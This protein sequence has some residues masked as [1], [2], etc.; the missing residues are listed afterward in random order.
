MNNKIVLLSLLV[1]S[2]CISYGQNTIPADI[3]TLSELTF[4]TNPIIKRNI[5]TVSNAEGG[6]K[7]QTSAF[8]YQL[9]SGLSLTRNN[10]NPFEADPRSSFLTGDLNSRFTGASVGLQRKFR[11]SFTVNLSVDYTM[12][13]DN[14][15]L[16]RFNQDVGAFTQEHIVTSTLSL[17]QPLLRGRGKKI[18][19]AL[20]EASKLNLESVDDN[21]EFANSFELL[22]LGTAYWQYVA[23]YKSLEVFE[24]N[25]ARV[26]RVLEITQE[27]VKADKKPAG[28][29]AQIQADLASQ[30]RQTKVAEQALYSAKLNLGRVI[31][32]SEEESKRLGNP[33]DEFPSIIE[34]GY[35]NNLN[36]D[37][38]KEIAQN[39]RLDIIAAK[40]TQEAIELQLNLAQNDKQPQLD[41][42]GFVSY[43]G[44]NMGNGLDRALATFS[45]NEGRDVGFGLGLRFSFP[46]NNNLARGRFIQNEVAF[47]DQEIAN[48]NLQRN[49]DLNV[50]IAMNNL[51]NSV[52]IL[53]KALESLEFYQEVFNNEQVK[54]QN[55]LTTL[56]NLILFQE[57]LTFAQLDYLQA[58]QQFA[59]AIINLR[60]E[61]GT[62]LLKKDNSTAVNINRELFYTIPSN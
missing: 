29:L 27:L 6:L 2:V 43:G 13:N 58:Q 39:N 23:A 36:I 46:V 62:L 10:L 9:T 41:L 24:Q 54:F 59:N 61:T 56:L 26:R 18:A 40:K 1:F 52:L 31:G 55:G 4:G 12:M 53:E 17:T 20:E 11:S 8:D 30:E 47:K 16:N 32:I 57:R 35:V 33:A 21:A 44:M 49:I 22:Q 19:T 3:V 60:Y 14:F 28:D 25:E 37:D 34:S 5:L 38:F 48:K 50:S 51:D 7:I 15:P 42:T 45:R